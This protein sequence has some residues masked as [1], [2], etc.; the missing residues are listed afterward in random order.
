MEEEKRSNEQVIPLRHYTMKELASMYG[1][2]KNTLRK[3]L[4]PLQESI[5]ER[6]GNYFSI[7]Q[8]KIIF[9]ALQLPSSVRVE[10]EGEYRLY[11]RLYPHL[12]PKTGKEKDEC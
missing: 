10:E 5:G 3:W 9:A 7:P 4:K 11:E 8:V 2:S 1:I 12:H 6:I